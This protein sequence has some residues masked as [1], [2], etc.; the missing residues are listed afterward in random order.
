MVK[1]SKGGSGHKKMASKAVVS[2]RVVSKTRASM[3]ESEYYAFVISMLGGSNC[4]VMCQDGIQRLCII[5]GKFRGSKG[6]RDNF[7]TKGCW[8]LVGARE[9]NSSSNTKKDG[10]YEKCDLLEVYKDNDKSFLKTISGINWTAFINND[11]S[12]SNSL[13]SNSNS[14]NDFDFSNDNVNDEYTSLISTSK[15]TG[16]I[17]LSFVEEEEEEEEGI[18]IDDI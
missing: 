17:S 9:W 7:I 13:S 8:V 2:S 15:T 12:I 4:H 6:K 11:L 14:N 10:E 18:D 1:N 5:R 16:V 3:D